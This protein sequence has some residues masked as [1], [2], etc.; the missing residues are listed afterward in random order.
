LLVV[1]P[2]PFQFAALGRMLVHLASWK[3]TSTWD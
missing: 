2:G 3:L 1:N